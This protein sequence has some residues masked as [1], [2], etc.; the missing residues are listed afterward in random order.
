M[1]FKKSVSFAKKTEP[2]STSSVLKKHGFERVPEQVNNM[3]IEEWVCPECEKINNAEKCT[4]C[5]HPRPVNT[6]EQSPLEYEKPEEIKKTSKE[7]KKYHK[8]AIYAASAVLLVILAKA[9]AFLYFVPKSNYDKATELADAGSYAEAEELYKKSGNYRDAKT[10]AEEMVR[11]QHKSNAERA[12]ADGDNVTAAEEFKAAGDIDNAAVYYYFAGLEYTEKKEYDKAIELFSSAE[13]MKASAF[14]DLESSK[15][16]VE[17]M[18]KYDAGEYEEACK[19]LLDSNYLIFD[20]GEL[21]CVKACAIYTYDCLGKGY[22]DKAEEIFDDFNLTWTLEN[23]VGN[24]QA[25]DNAIYLIKAECA[26]DQGK[27]NTAKELFEQTPENSTY[28]EIDREKR[29]EA[30]AS[31]SGLLPMCGEWSYPEG[32]YD[33]SEG[34][35][36]YWKDLS[37]EK[38][39]LSLRFYIDDDGT[40]TAQGSLD[41]SVISYTLSDLGFSGMGRG[42][43]EEKT[44]VFKTVVKNGSRITVGDLGIAVSYSNGSLRV[45]ATT[46]ERRSISYTYSSDN[47]VVA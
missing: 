12:A 19:L 22:Y 26:F 42:R 7:S 14:S 1:M 25:W 24:L 36:Y 3:S 34:M 39:A 28:E 21:H 43:T 15:K 46:G 32:K 23:S 47:H 8:A 40:I 27:L 6:P 13:N 11:R 17:G 31:C 16:Y 4:V 37:D 20:D 10:Q 41:Y 35:Y 5:G 38:E 30:I 33:Y 9:S 29:L 2:E 44:E 18:K 45:S